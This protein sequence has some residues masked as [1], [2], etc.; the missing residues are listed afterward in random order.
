MT[1]EKLKAAEPLFGSWLVE[2][3]IAEGRGSKFYKVY[4]TE[5]GV[6]H[7]RGLKT[8][9]FPSDNAEISNMISS[10]QFRNID[11][12]LDYLQKAISDNM[13]TMISLRSNKNIVQFDSFT[14]I[15]EASC[16][17]V[18]M[19]ME[20]L[21]PLSQHMK[22][23]DADKT[24]VLRLGQDLC[25]ALEGFRQA[26]IMHRCIRSENIFVDSYGNYK[27][28]DFG[29]SPSDYS[30]HD[31]SALLAPEIYGR[32]A[33]MDI[34]SDIYALGMLLYKLLNHNRMPFLPDYPLPV[35]LSDR[36]N[37]RSKCMRGDLF[38]APANSDYELTTVIFKATAFLPSARF[39]TPALLSAELHRCA[40]TLAAPAEYI[41]DTGSFEIGNTEDVRF[42]SYEDD[43]ELFDEYEREPDDEQ[44][45]N[46]KPGKHWYFIVLGLGVILALVVALI[47]AGEAKKDKEPATEHTT[48]APVIAPTTQPTT[49]EATTEETTT[50]ETTTEE[51]TT[52]ETTTE[53]TTT[54]ETTTEE[55]TTEETT[56]EETT[57]KETTEPM[58]EPTLVSTDKKNGDKS[59]DGKT[60]L[61]ITSFKVTEIPD[62]EFFDKT[63][64]TIGDNLGENLT[65]TDVSLYQ[66]AGASVIQK[67]PG[68]LLCEADSQ[69]NILCTITV[70]DSDFYY[71]PDNFQY[72]LCFPEGAIISDSFITLPLQIKL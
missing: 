20:L 26:G 13:N 27:L 16:F 15:R 48:A 57:T 59:E 5:G 70:E 64:V 36:E 3:K 39:L 55:T 33:G 29:I 35:L 11:E 2:S 37:A 19:L 66:M 7:Y 67:V 54:E 34:S 22:L 25:S 14:I 62:D 18:V 24:E 65:C 28:G 49:E 8:L 6:M 43:T 68:K 44:E 45:E 9:R 42:D 32:K 53:E 60:Y 17:Y 23:D 41:N 58:T 52:E 4:K 47:F 56:T 38:P 61:K 12:Y 46:E 69:D 10:S 1:L 51:T 72:Y 40:L 31:P 21:T 63:V 71:E 30:L 50:E